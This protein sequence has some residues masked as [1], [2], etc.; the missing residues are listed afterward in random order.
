MTTSKS[1]NNSIK[2]I[3]IMVAI[4]IIF[5]SSSLIGYSYW[6]L[7][8]DTNQSIIPIGEWRTPISTAQEFYDYLTKDD[9]VS[10]DSYYLINDI[11]FSDF[12][13][14]LN[15][16]NNDVIFR[17]TLDGDGYT[18]SNLTIRTNSS[19]Y[20]KIGIFPEINGGTV[21]NLVLDNVEIS[22]GSNALGAKKLK[23]GLIAGEISGGGTPLITNIT[24]IDCGVRAT[25]GAGAGGIVGFVNGNN[26]ELTISNIKA[27]GLKV[28]NKTANSGS[29]IGQI[30]K[31]T[32]SVTIGNIDME[33]EIFA[34]NNKSYTGGVVGKIEA[35]A[36]LTISNAIIEAYSINTLETDS[37]WY[38]KNTKRYLGGIIGYS[39]TDS[40]KLSI[41]NVFF[42]GDLITNGTAQSIDIGTAIGLN[43]G[44]YTMS[45][46]YY[47]MVEFNHLDGTIGYTPESGYTGVFSTLVNE[48]S[49][50]SNSW[51]DNFAI[52]F[53]NSIWGQDSSGRLYLIR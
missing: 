45:N 3:L 30:N 47:S 42:T 39:L 23:G 11:D 22:L 1:F 18:I 32:K 31:N 40:S 13:W 21:K 35:G 20:T 52:N 48:S 44:S 38:N 4:A 43:D 14:K 26:T 37:N 8:E 36:S 9:S 2:K 12:T 17:G 24:I 19:T 27:T 50:P 16:S 46:T 53:D 6:D 10:G 41:T 28:F 15:S 49:M 34:Y 29:I 33:A 25:K 51:W 7:L 5:S